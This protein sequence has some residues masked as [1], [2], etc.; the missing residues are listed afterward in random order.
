MKA[1][2]SF[3]P[4][5][6]P[7]RT[8]LMS[9]S[10]VLARRKPWH[11]HCGD[12][13][14]GAKL[15][16]DNCLHT[17]C[18]SPPYF[19]L[20]DYG[21][22]GQIGLEETPDAY[23][24]KLVELFRE[25]RRALHPSGSFWLNL[26]DSY[27]NAGSSNNGTGLD[28]ERRGGATGA[29]GELGYKKRDNRSA[30]ADIGIKRKDLI[31]IPWLVAFAL[32]ADGW[33]LR[34]WM[35]WV[36]RNPMPESATDRPGTSCE[37]VFLLA[38]NADYSFD[39]EAVKRDL[40]ED[41]IARSGRHKSTGEN[42]DRA[43]GGNFVG[44][45]GDSRNF[46]SGDLFF[47]SLGMILAGDIDGTD[48]PTILGMDVNVNS[49]R[50]A[51]FAT[52]PKKLV[53]PMILAGSSERGVCPHCLAP[54]ER[55]VA[56]NRFA[57]RPGTGSKLTGDNLTD[58]NRDPERHVTKTE[59]VGWRP[60]C[61]CPAHDPVPAIVYDPF[62]GSGTTGKVALELGRS[63]LGTELNP[64]YMKLIEDRMATAQAPLF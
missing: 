22:E 35:P 40:A 6:T 23:A 8:P 53:A 13:L 32:R 10:D 29:D 58:G 39:M 1:D 30:W 47:D 37:T 25:L 50:G 11:V 64:E 20:R 7:N 36:K 28:S 61:K 57:T 15:L 49:Y 3:R 52:W 59:T 54:H 26:G 43:D 63:F 33:Y 17:I 46:R 56:K 45:S 44:I 9:I 18:T 16:P 4:N 2:N 38:K 34:Q 48:D 27:N 5:D 12:A 62:T 21:H 14:A 51:H 55:I 42:P 31:G 24:A 41:S 60:T 19:G